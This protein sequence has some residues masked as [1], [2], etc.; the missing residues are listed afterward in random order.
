MKKN[1]SQV[2]PTVD[3]LQFISQFHAWTI[4]LGTQ[5]PVVIN[6]LAKD[7][8]TVSMLAKAINTPLDEF[9]AA[10]Q[11]VDSLATSDTII[12]DVQ[13]CYLSSNGIRWEK[14]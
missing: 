1:L 14:H 5:A 7:Q 9:T 12:T 11:Q 4:Q 10:D 6:T 2:Y 3:N 8:L 13:H